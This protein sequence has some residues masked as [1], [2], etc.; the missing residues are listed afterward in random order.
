[1]RTGRVITFNSGKL[2]NT[3]KIRK[4]EGYPSGFPFDFDKQEMVLNDNIDSHIR[5]AC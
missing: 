2:Y 4:L 5:M 1:M 3:P